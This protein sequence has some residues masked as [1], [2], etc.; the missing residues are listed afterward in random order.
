PVEA[1]RALHAIADTLMA[2]P[3]SA[4]LE[5]DIEVVEDE[6]SSGAI[7]PPRTLS[8]AEIAASTTNAPMAPRAP[9]DL[10]GITPAVRAR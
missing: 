8:L 7:S 4:D 6:P 1:V 10:P 2:E 9:R 5:V 3:I